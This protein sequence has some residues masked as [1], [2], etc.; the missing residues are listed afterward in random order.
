MVLTN[1]Y[2][3]ISRQRL[4]KITTETGEI[5]NVGYSAPGCS[6]ATPSNDAQNTML[7]YPVYWYP[8]IQQSPIKDYFNKYIVQ[9]VTEQDATDASGDDTISTTYTPVGSPAWHYNDNPLMPSS[10]ATWDQFRATPA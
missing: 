9:T 3:W 4:T 2:P 10:R 7:C 5:I 1:G 8:T 6:G